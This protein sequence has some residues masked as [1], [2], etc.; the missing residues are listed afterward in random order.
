MSKESNGRV[1]IPKT[2]S[3]HPKLLEAAASRMEKLRC[4]NFT[5]YVISCVEN[6]IVRSGAKLPDL[7]LPDIVP[8]SQRTSLKRKK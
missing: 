6:E 3:I 1:Y 8:P 4:K 5:E 2:I 7:V